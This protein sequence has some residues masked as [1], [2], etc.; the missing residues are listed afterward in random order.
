MMKVYA[1]W[2]EGDYRKA[3]TG[4]TVQQPWSVEDEKAERLIKTLAL[5]GGSI[6][7]SDVQ[8]VDSPVVWRLFFTKWISALSASQS[9][10][11]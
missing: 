1:H 2:L 3:L 7:L 9:R 8:V 6:V 11:H 5:F 10:L 4:V